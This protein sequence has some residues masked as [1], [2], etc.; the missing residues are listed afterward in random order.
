MES[1][2]SLHHHLHME[3]TFHNIYIMLG[4]VYNTVIVWTELRC[5][6]KSCWH[7]SCWHKSCCHKSCRHKSC[8]HKSYSH[9]A[10]LLRS[11]RYKNYMVVITILLAIFISQITMDLPLFTQ[12]FLLSSITDKTLTILDYIYMSNTYEKHDLLTSVSTWVHPLFLVRS[13]LILFLVFW[14]VLFCLFVCPVSCVSNVVSFPGL[15][16]FWLPLLFSLTFIYR[17]ITIQ[18]S[19]RKSLKIPNV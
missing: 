12:I 8:W 16:V 14:V 17:Y 5:W 9:K 18:I 4:C 11:H 3:F 19:G 10:T 13:V 7:K 1:F 2:N 6:H 15:S